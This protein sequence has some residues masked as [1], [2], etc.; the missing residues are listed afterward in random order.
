MYIE[1]I[2]SRP[3]EGSSTGELRLMPDSMGIPFQRGKVDAFEVAARNIGNPHTV[4]VWH[5]GT[6]RHPDWHLEYV[7]IRR[8]VGDS[9]QA[10][11]PC[12]DHTTAHGYRFP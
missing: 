3:A 7:K 4:R 12:M 5:D 6:G 11:L 1:L 2:G 8:K 9:Q 10:H